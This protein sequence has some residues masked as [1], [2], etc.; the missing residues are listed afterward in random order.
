[1]S[2]YIGQPAISI[3]HLFKILVKYLEFIF[4]TFDGIS[5]HPTFLMHGLPLLAIPRRRA[6]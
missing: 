4:S 2:I 3:I 1:M 6:Y 5:C